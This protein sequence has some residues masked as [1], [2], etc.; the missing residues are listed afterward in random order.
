MDGRPCSSPQDIA[1]HWFGIRDLWHF[2]QV[3]ER[4]LAGSQEQHEEKI[5]ERHPRDQDEF[6]DPKLTTA[7]DS[8]DR[9][10]LFVRLTGA[11]VLYVGSTAGSL[12]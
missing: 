4:D 10:A 12:A 8:S 2:L 5:R 6:G 9:K 11:L 7:N 3:L 1:S